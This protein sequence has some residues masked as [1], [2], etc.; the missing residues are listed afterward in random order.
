RRADPHRGSH[1]AARTRVQGRIHTQ[2]HRAA[3]LS[4][5]PVARRRLRDDQLPVFTTA[6][7]HGLVPAFTFAISLLV[8]RSTIDTSLDG[9]LAANRYLPSGD[10][11]MPHGR[12]PTVM[13]SSTSKLFVSTTATVPP[14]PV[15]A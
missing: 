15:L 7:P 8:A 11:A 3:D 13:L 2:H 9:P 10:S 5:R 4:G 1:H 12:L 14:R 6:T